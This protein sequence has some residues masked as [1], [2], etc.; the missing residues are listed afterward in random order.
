[1]LV[2]A[3]SFASCKDKSDSSADINKD[4]TGT[5]IG[6]YN[7]GFYSILIQ[8]DKKYP[9]GKTIKYIGPPAYSCTTL[10]NDG[11]YLNV[12]QVQGTIPIVETTSKMMNKRI[13]FSYRPY[14]YEK[15]SALFSMGIGNGVCCN[16]EVP[17]YVMTNYQILN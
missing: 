7:N 15:D 16:P 4:V 2:L 5:V 10:P 9:I 6:Y 8:V 12:I 1:M 14:Q 3:G 11:T 13:S 17:V